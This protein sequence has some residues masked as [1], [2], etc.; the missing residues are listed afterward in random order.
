M[1][2]VG[3]TTF[4]MEPNCQGVRIPNAFFPGTICETSNLEK[5]KKIKHIG[6]MQWKGNPVLVVVIALDA[7][8]M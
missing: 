6:L 8:M 7:S 2:P 1:F 5:V 3:A 4:C